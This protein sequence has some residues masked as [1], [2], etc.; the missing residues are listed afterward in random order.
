MVGSYERDTEEK[1]MR[2]DR[3]KD[4]GQKHITMTDFGIFELM[5]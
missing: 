5:N 2:D 3:K 4:G 1:M